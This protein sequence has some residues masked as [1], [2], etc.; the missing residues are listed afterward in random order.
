MRKLVVVSIGFTASREAAPAVF[1]S[2]ASTPVFIV[3]AL[4][5]FASLIYH[6]P[7]QRLQHFHG[8]PVRKPAGIRPFQGRCRP[9]PPRRLPARAAA[10]PARSISAARTA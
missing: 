5:V 7:E 9:S 8:L 4:T 10:A 3:S 1:G 6:I 2:L